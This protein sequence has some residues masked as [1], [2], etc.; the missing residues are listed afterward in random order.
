MRNQEPQPRS[1][2]AAAATRVRALEAPCHYQLTEAG[3]DDAGDLGAKT[4]AWQA[5]LLDLSWHMHL[6][7]QAQKGS[8]LA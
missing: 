4:R 6:P 1:H 5:L 3:P 7:S 8:P 2:V